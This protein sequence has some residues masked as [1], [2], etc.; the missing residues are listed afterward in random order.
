[1]QDDLLCLPTLSGDIGIYLTPVLSLQ[2]FLNAICTHTQFQIIRLVA[3]FT[4]QNGTHLL[5]PKYLAI[6]ETGTKL[7][8]TARVIQIMTTLIKLR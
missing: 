5:C 6:S 7:W 8:R 2:V 4:L 3:V 1:M